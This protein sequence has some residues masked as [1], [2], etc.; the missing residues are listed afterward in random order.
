MRVHCLVLSLEFLVYAH[1]HPT[2]HCQTEMYGS[3]HKE[4]LALAVRGDEEAC[5]RCAARVC[6]LCAAVCSRAASAVPQ[7]VGTP[8]SPL[9]LSCP[10]C[11]APLRPPRRL[12]ASGDDRTFLVALLLHSADISNPTKPKAVQDK[13]APA[14]PCTCMHL[15]AAST[16]ALSLAAHR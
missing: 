12:K 9:M 6:S 8:R 16:H 11:A 7:G 2:A 13:S 10:A 5:Q 4:D 15:H 3:V 14:P 1:P